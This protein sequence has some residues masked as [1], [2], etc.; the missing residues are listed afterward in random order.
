MHRNA[1]IL[2]R[3]G[4]IF[5][6]P[7]RVPSASLRLVSSHKGRIVHDHSQPAHS[8]TRNFYNHV[9]LASFGFSTSD[10]TFGAGHASFKGSD[11]N[12]RN[13]AY[14]S[15]SWSAINLT[16]DSSYGIVAGR[17]ST[18]ES[19]DSYALATI[20]SHGTGANQL[21][22]RAM[23]APS[24]NYTA[25]TRTFD[26]T[27][28]RILDNLSGSTITVT[29]TGIYSSGYPGYYNFMFCRDLLASS[30][31]VLNNGSLTVSYTV[32]LVFPS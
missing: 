26:L 21:S 25:G 7:F 15:Y 18:A 11:G 12:V 28:K 5:V 31:D 9:F 23:S 17:G 13:F 19:F 14:T 6:P 10:S 20:C 3:S 22:Y 30:V 16:A 2:P 24:L 8:Y 4:D 27:A 1:L 32:S 29:E